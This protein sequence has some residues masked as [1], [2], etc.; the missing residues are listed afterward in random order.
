[1]KSLAVILTY[2]GTFVFLYL[3]FSLF[4]VIWEDYLTIIRT[5]EWIFAYSFLLGWWL[6]IFPAHEV[7]EYY[8]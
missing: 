1:M 5:K 7:Y 6:A 3:F 4:G 8:Y 2:F